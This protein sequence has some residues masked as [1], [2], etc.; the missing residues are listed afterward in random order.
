MVKSSLYE[1]NSFIAK[2]KKKKVWGEHLAGGQFFPY[3]A[4]SFWQVLFYAQMKIIIRSH[5][6]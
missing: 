1:H 4:R 2:K 5:K 6:R 3:T